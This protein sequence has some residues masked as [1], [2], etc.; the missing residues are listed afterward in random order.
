MIAH[1]H[2][3]LAIKSVE[4]VVV[5]VQGVGYRVMI[6][7]ST[8]YTLPGLHESVTLLTTMHVR[9]DAMRLYGFATEDERTLFEALVGVSSIGPRLA[10]NMLSSIPAAELQQAIAYGDVSRLQSIPGIGKKTAERVVLELQE[11][12]GRLPTRA[13]AVSL[14]TAAWD[15]DYLVGDV[16]SALLNLGYKRAEAEKAIQATRNADNGTV[17]LELML[18]DALQQLAR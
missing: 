10:L 2:G 9:E 6:P 14:D 7:L 15:A 18:K 13:H 8:Y 17:T 3:H 4:Q 1:L 5:D 12:I 16:V 11:K